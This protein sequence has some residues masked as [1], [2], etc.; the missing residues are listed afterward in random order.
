MDPVIYPNARP[1]TRWWW[2]SGPIR[3]EDVRAQLD[4]LKAN[5]FGGVEIAWI[6]P[7][8]GS[9]P[10][11]GWL[12][13][14]WS[15]TVAYAKGYAQKIGLGCD[16]TFG[17]LWPFGGSIVEERDASRTFQGLSPQRLG[18]SWEERD[19]PPGFIL[20]HLDRGALERYAK[21]MGSGLSEALKEAPSALFCDSWEVEPEGLWTGGFDEAF[22]RR[23]GYDLLPYMAS[24]DDHPDVRYDYRALLSEFVLNEFYV[25]YTEECHRLGALSRVQCHG[26]PTDLLAAYAAADVPESEAIL[27]DPHFSQFAASAAA[28]SGPTCTEA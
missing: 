17:T 14:E 26:A 1:Y 12:S 8:P 7:L 24:L 3:E 18:R 5:G 9:E 11:P 20:N 13:G 4:W 21:K 10:G 19:S 15:R 16:F 22:L 2:F 27:F 28:L 23:F 6:Y 25:P